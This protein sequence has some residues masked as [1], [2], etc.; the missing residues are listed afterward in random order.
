MKS[1]DIYVRSSQKDKVGS[2]CAI[3]AYGSATREL[4]GTI[5]DV[6][7]LVLETTAV[8]NGL[9]ALK[10]SCILKIYSR[11][12]TLVRIGKGEWEA[13][14][15]LELWEE[16]NNVATNHLMEWVRVDDK[17]NMPLDKR[18]H[19]IAVSARKNS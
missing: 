13:H 8:I 14:K 18:C 1:V 4:T 11:N 6:T 16:L 2:W 9:K 10:E 12:E 3:L 19:Q 15:Y 7:S 17:D 5:N